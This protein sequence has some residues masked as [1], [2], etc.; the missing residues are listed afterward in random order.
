MSKVFD[1]DKEIQKVLN[2]FLFDI[3]S[4]DWRIWLK[5]STK[6]EYEEY[7]LK[8]S[9]FSSFSAMLEKETLDSKAFSIDLDPFI[10][11][12]RYSD[13]IVLCHTSGTTNSNINAL[14]WF[15]MSKNV[16]SRYWA[17]GM[18]AIFE[19]SGLTSTKS[20]VIFV[21]SRTNL[22]G[23]RDLNNKQYLSLYS[24]EFSQRTMLSIIKPK[25]YLLY[26]YKKSK[27]LDIISKILSMEDIS[28]ISAPAIT[29]LGWADIEKLEK[30]LIKSIESFKKKTNNVDNNLI[31]LIEREGI[32]KATKIIQEKLSEKL[33]RT[34]IIFSTSSLSEQDWIL[35][36][37]FMR[38]KKGEEKFTNLYVASEVGPIAS[39]LGN[40][41]VSRTNS[42]FLFPLTLDVLEYKGK[43]DI[44]S[45]TEN[46][47]GK[48]LVSRFN[49]EEILTNI[50]LGDIIKIKTQNGL[51]QIEGRI[52]H[53]KF[54]L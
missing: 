33:S 41:D 46:L 51:P 17:P 28:V 11:N 15:H 8:N 18:Q 26:E 27:D 42:M 54:E 16:V 6:E 25:S 1:F 24:S 2:A 52:L 49:N 5:L 13:P 12:Y 31:H 23:I 10:K 38:W 44:I 30:G 50:D 14:K 32:I 45:R 43:K 39:S 29:I 9:G 21:P 48:L 37:K 34:T 53:A 19:S 36:R 20:A 35:I 47:I 4:T 3:T 40:F 7:L 22:D